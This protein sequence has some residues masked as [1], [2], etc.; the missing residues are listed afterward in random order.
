MIQTKKNKDEITEDINDIKAALKFREEE[1][2]QEIDDSHPEIDPD[3]VP[4]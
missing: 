4:F 2:T 1:T 3:D